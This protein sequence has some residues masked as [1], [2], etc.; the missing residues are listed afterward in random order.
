[1]KDLAI[2]KLKKFTTGTYK[3]ITNLII[4]GMKNEDCCI[5]MES[6]EKRNKV[7]VITL[8]DARKQV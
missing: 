4:G 7:K 5:G 1:M 2:N 3:L 6:I 8:C